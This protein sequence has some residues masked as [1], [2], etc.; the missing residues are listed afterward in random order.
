MVRQHL[1]N[2]RQNDS[3]NSQRLWWITCKECTITSDTANIFIII[4]IRLQQRQML[5]S[6][7][8]NKLRFEMF[9]NTLTYWLLYPKTFHINCFKFNEASFQIRTL[10]LW[11]I[12]AGLVMGWPRWSGWR[13]FTDCS[14]R[15]WA[16]GSTLETWNNTCQENKQMEKAPTE[17]MESLPVCVYTPLHRKIEKSQ[18]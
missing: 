9:T 11:T 12:L 3:Y 10:W 8:C 7:S 14:S 15:R 17:S 16:W 18:K 5:A 6:R 13:L 2:L 4:W 1:E